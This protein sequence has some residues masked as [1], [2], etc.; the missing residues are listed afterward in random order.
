MLQQGA[1]IY[2]RDLA[3]LLRVESGNLTRKLLEL[4]K[5]GVLK[6]RW[7]GKQRYYSLNKDFPLL[8]EYKNIVLKTIGLEQMF[9]SSLA[10]ISGI[11]KAI[12]FGSYAQDKMDLHSDVDLLVI[13]DHGTVDLNRVVAQVQKSINRDINAVSMSLQEYNDR[14]KDD[15]FL[16]SIEAK[17]SIKII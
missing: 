17:K 4:E 11:K 5:E 13:G 7:L 1:E 10:V 14:K 8:K 3:R 15:P 6:S 16:M 9:K 2:V 12:I